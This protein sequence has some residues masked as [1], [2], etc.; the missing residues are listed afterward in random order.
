MSRLWTTLLLCLLMTSPALGNWADNTW[1][2]RRALDVDWP[3]NHA[4]QEDLA[5]AEFFTAGH[6]QPSGENIRVATEE[7]KYVPSHVLMIG[8]GDRMRI[9]FAPIPG[10]HRYY[11]YFGHPNPSP[12]QR[13]TEDVV[14]HCGVLLNMHKLNGGLANDFKDI[15]PLWQRSTQPIGQMLLTHL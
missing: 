11:V 7:G 8:P 6:H 5:T 9:V 14:Y 2:F 12:P 13:G 4:P 1:P 3:A 10:V 15:E